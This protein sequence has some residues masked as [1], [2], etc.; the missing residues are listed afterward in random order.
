LLKHSDNL[1]QIEALLFGQAGLLD[2]DVGDD[3]YQLL[4][5]E[6]ILL[7]GKYSLSTNLKKAHWKFLRL[8]P[9]NFPTIRIAQ[10]AS[11]IFSIKNIFSVLLETDEPRT[12]KNLFS[13]TQSPYWQEHYQFNRKAKALITGFGE[14]SIDNVMINTV[15]PL[16]VAYG[17]THANQDFVD[18]AT[19][20]LQQLN[21]ENNSII[22]K[23]QSLMV[24]AE[25]ASDSQGLIELHNSFCVAKKCLDCNVGAAIIKPSNLSKNNFIQS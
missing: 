8:R 14:A 12:L 18:R 15:A 5:R 21:P 23:W 2:I 24:V 7:K 6:Y 9:A 17:K 22:R 1:T 11:L 4:R 19:R 16:L 20:L 10:F 3:Y 13:A 25:N